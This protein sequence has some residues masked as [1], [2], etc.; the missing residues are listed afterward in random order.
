[1]AGLAHNRAARLQS[2]NGLGIATPLTYAGV[3]TLDIFF[4]DAI[5]NVTVA[6][7][8]R[9]SVTSLHLGVADDTYVHTP[10]AVFSES[11]MHVLCTS[12]CIP[13]VPVMLFCMDPFH[14]SP[15]AFSIR[16][17]RLT[18]GNRWPCL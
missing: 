6:S 3:D 5:N 8:E 16:S 2:I 1:M 11:C 9:N 4:S 10:G 17:F 12:P 7:T 13:S 14:S 18:T 15:R